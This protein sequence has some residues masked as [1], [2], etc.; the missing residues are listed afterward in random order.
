MDLVDAGD[1][2]WSFTV[3]EPTITYTPPPLDHTVN[4]GD[5]SWTFHVS[6][7]TVTHIPLVPID[8][9]IDAGDVVVVLS[10]SLSRQSRTPHR[11]C[12]QWMLGT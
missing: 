11:P 5:V 10:T 1:V 7:P 4:A 2:D 3:P 8:H 9:R 12:T 6:Q